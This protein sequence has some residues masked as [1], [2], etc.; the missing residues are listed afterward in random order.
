MI[1]NK[2]QSKRNRVNLFISDVNFELIFL[3]FCLI[4]GLDRIDVNMRLGN[5]IWKWK[6][7]HGRSCNQRSV[8]F[9]DLGVYKKLKIYKIGFVFPRVV[10]PSTCGIRTLWPTRR[11]KPIYFSFWQNYPL[12]LLYEVILESFSLWSYNYLIDFQRVQ[13]LV[14]RNHLQ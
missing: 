6:F 4:F 3:I 10:V 9:G 12:K 8:F 13:W 7:S 2:P 5:W 1:K 11:R 14:L